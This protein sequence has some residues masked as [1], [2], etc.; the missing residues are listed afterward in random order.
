MMQ[1]NQDT[2]QLKPIVNFLTD[3]DLYKFTMDQLFLHKYPWVSGEYY[4]LCRNEGTVFTP[5]MKVEIDKQIKHLCTLTMTEKELKYLKTIRFLKPDY[6]EF[7]RIWR[8]LIDY[9]TTYLNADGS[10]TIK[11]SGPLYMAMHFEIY[12]LEIV[13]E[14]YFRMN[15]DYDE[16]EKQAR[17]KLKAKVEALNSN[18]YTFKFAE[19]GA[20]RRLS[21]EWQAEVVRELVATGKCVG[22]SN[23]KLACDNKVPAIGT[24]AHELVQM[25]QGIP[26]INLAY[27]NHYVL[28][29]WIDEY[30]GDLGTALTDTIGTEMFFM[31]LTLEEAKLLSGFRHDSGDPIAWGEYVLAQLKR[32]GL[33]DEEIKNKLLLFSDS[34]NFDKAQKIYDYFKDRCKV[35]FGIGTFLSNDTD[36]EPLNIVVKLQFVTVNGRRTPVAKLSDVPGKTLCQVPEFVDTLKSVIN[37]EKTI[38]NVPSLAVYNQ[39]YNLAYL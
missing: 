18:K 21:F 10:L 3:T 6:I 33:T 38:N 7:L 39:K 9:V 14:V 8:P 36:V 35:S 2:M 23:V 25:Y 13:N 12:V 29:D 28:R 4:F 30:G 24:F 16:L 11:V 26:G 31:V 37:Y 1:L 19:F 22:T 15:Y 17:R 20:R 34:L 32:I 27:I 5:A